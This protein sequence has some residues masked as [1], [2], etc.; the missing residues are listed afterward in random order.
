MRSILPPTCSP[1]GVMDI[2]APMEKKIM[3]MITSTDPMRNSTRILGERAAMVNP[4]A[5]TISTM[6]ST[7]LMD[8]FAFSFAFSFSTDGCVPNLPINFLFS[9][10][11]SNSLCSAAADMDY[12]TIF[13]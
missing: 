3:P 6:G 7:A 2:S 1:I 8:S 5:R 10:Y 11:T 9:T 4:S 12:S 13:P